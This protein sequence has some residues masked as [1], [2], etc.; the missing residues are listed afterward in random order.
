MI[1]WL[2]FGA[3]ALGWLLTARM[4][5]LNALE[6]IACK[7][8]KHRLSMEESYR[9]MN[10]AYPEHGQPLVDGEDRALSLVISSLTSLVWPVVL[11]VMLMSRSL[12]A[13]SEKLYSDRLELEKLRAQAKAYGLPFGDEKKEDRS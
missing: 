1:G 2:I 8:L 5:T 10:A 13:P 9:K 11:L 12:R 7:A 6:S 3:Y 4:M